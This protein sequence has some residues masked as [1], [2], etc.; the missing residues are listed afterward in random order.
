MT[1]PLDYE[2]EAW[3]AGCK[4]VVGLDEVGRGALAGPVLVGAVA[5]HPGQQFDGC[6]DSK[7]LTAARRSELTDV[8]VER[9]L[10][11][12]LGAASTKEVDRYSVSGATALAMHRALRRFPAEPDLLLVD[13]I[14]K[15]AGLGARQIAIVRGD[16]ASHSIAC[17]S[18]VAKT[19]RDRL[20]DRL[21]PRYPGYGWASNKGYSNRAHRRT[22]RECGPTPHHRRSFR[23]TLVPRFF[24]GDGGS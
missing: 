5:L 20:M 9:S 4:I 14:S 21:D 15:I 6:D 22:L 19:V 11:C 17:A 10:L 18:V 7:S 16:S 2:S 8:I 3:A 23:G 1:A 24:I 13:G 12:Q